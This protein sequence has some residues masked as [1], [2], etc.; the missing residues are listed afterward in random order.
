MHSSKGVSMNVER[1][2]FQD[3]DV[4]KIKGMSKGSYRPVNLLVQLY[5]VTCQ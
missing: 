1:R 2:L 4:D 5:E 3:N